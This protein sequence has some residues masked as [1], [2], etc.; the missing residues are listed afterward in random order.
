MS[1]FPAYSSNSN[2]E[3]KS[4][5]EAQKSSDEVSN[6]WLENSS[7]VAPVVQTPVIDLWSDSS[8]DESVK[9]IFND[10]A[11]SP[12]SEVIPI[13]LDGSISSDYNRSS[14]SRRER[15]H[16][17]RKKKTRDRSSHR[18]KEKYAKILENVYFEDTARDKRNLTVSTL[19]GSDRPSYTLYSAHLGF[20]PFKKLLKQT[21]RRYHA[22]NIDSVRKGEKQDTR[23]KRSQT[24]DES[25]QLQNEM[26]D[27]NWGVN[28]EEEQT[29]KTKEFNEGLAENPDD[30]ELWMKYINFQD[31]ISRFQK[32][33]GITD[34]RNTITCQRK[35]AIAN[36]AFEKNPSSTELLKLKLSL[37][38]QLLPADQFSSEVEALVNKDSG[39]IVLWRALIMA[40]QASVAIC[41]VPKVLDLY[42]RC[43]SSLRQRLR[44][45]PR[46]YDQQILEMLYRCLTFLRQAGLWEQM[47]E[48]LR[49]N[50][51][52]NLNLSK[53]NFRFRGFIDERKLI[54]MEEVILTSRLPLNQLWLRVESLRESCHWI[55][56]SSDQLEVLGDSRRF[57][58]PEDVTDFVQPIMSRD[59]S[60]KLAVYSILSLKV[61]LLPMQDFIA[62]D[63]GLTQIEWDADSI[64]M[65]L[66]LVHPFVGILAGSEEKKKVME[67]ILEDQLTSGPQYL[68]YHPAQEPY[69]D[70]VRDTFWAIA[71]SFSA[72]QYERTS[73]YVWW[74]RFERLLASLN[75]N[76][77]D[78]H[79]KKKLKSM[80]KD[81]LKRDGNRNNLHFYREY[82]LIE[83]EI[84][85]FDS[86]VN[87]LET[88]IGMQTNFLAN[89]S[90]RQE[91]TVLCSVFR[92]LFETLLDP[93]TYQE[94]HRGRI[95]TA[96]ARMVSGPDENRLEQAEEFL[97]TSVDEFLRQPVSDLIEKTYFL[98][99]FECDL[100]TCYA[101]FLYVKN[102]TISEPIGVLEKCLKHSKENKYLQECLY[103][104]T[105][106]LWHLDSKRS[107]LHGISK[108]TL[109]QALDLYPMNCYLLSVGMEIESESPCWKVSHHRTGSFQAMAS[110]LAIHIRIERLE[111]LGLQD[112]AVAATNKL[113]SIHRRLAKDPG[114]QRCPL[115]WR[116]YMLFLRER[117]LCEGRGEEVYH[118]SVAE[119]P[120]ARG[121]YTDAAQVAPQLL[122]EIQDLI[123]EKELRMHVTPEELD[124]LRG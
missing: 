93:K 123:R 31:V 96:V 52:L 111:S 55:S 112:A 47:W 64:E 101:Y 86:C 62:H 100:I 97:E 90:T 23:I 43:L 120:W 27:F 83:K 95:L 8:S 45:S 69:L 49:L 26:E 24:S 60:L 103:E 88:T 21:P 87:I 18:Q 98:P 54:G 50:L 22:V 68:K 118:E 42:S 28:M 59:S 99:N 67:R 56:V 35:L 85:R 2:N 53:D 17:K 92:A 7:F 29:K 108:E 74:L 34:V 81:F 33:R 70:F 1:L 116:L 51:T 66:P 107:K 94:N 102:S 115:I 32:D 84:G 38:A 110:C 113:L 10:S 25:K 12:K 14:T 80:V 82:A 105:V 73:I 44:T 119:C 11:P 6:L 41:T 71:E 36:K 40:T 63:L 117:N 4:L 122:T 20:R 104:S 79:R 15:K 5:D 30:V 39:N 48:T 121:I 106:A 13:D 65:L 16:K 91:K 89:L 109:D 58:L 78:D 77:K 124:I 75:K 76:D 3:A 61:P 46:L 9:I 114:S 37:T 57:V 72:T 19:G